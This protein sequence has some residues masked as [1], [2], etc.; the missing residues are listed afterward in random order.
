MF[1]KTVSVI[2]VFIISWLHFSAFRIYCITDSAVHANSSESAGSVHIRTRGSRSQERL[3][4]KAEYRLAMPNR[5]SAAQSAGLVKT[6]GQCVPN[7]ILRVRVFARHC[8]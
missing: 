6:L 1:R 5:L 7:S 4:Q 3:K 2:Y 8:W